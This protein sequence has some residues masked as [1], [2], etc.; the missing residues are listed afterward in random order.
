MTLWHRRTWLMVLR[1]S[2]LGFSMKSL[3]LFY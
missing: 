1:S 2:E 3:S